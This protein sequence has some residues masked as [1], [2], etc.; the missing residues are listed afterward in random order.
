VAAELDRD[1]GAG[2]QQPA[3]A[4]RLGIAIAI[5]KL[6]QHQPDQQHPHAIESGSSSFVTHVV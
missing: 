4:E 5:R 2:E 3:V 1:V 6:G